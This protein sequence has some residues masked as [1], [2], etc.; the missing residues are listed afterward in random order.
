[1]LEIVFELVQ[2]CSA[3]AQGV[4]RGGPIDPRCSGPPA[5]AMAQAPGMFAPAVND[6]HSAQALPG[7]PRDAYYGRSK[8]KKQR[9][10]Y[11]DV[12]ARG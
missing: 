10:G 1:M 6:L 8:R 2:L 11:S 4:F 3:L 9:W 7:K 5:R 12:L